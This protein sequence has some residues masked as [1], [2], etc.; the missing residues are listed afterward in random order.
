VLPN[1]PRQH[2]LAEIVFAKALRFVQSLD[3]HVGAE[4]IVSHRRKGVG[5]PS[6][7]GRGP[8]RL[9]EEFAHAPLG[10]GVDNSEG[11]GLRQRHGERRDR[12]FGLA[13]QVKFDHLADVHPVDVVGAENQ[14]QVRFVLLDQIEV[15]QHRIG[16]ALEPPGVAPKHLRRHDG[17]ELAGQ[18]GRQHPG[19]AHVLDKFLR[20][21]LDQ[22]IDR[23]DPGIDQVRQ[24]EVHDAVT[25]AER[26]RRLGTLRGQRIEARALPAGHDESKNPATAHGCPP[27]QISEMM[28]VVICLWS[29][30]WISPVDIF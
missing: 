15:L 9:L 12:H 26:D 25:T 11:A 5:G 1:Q 17:H 19:L 8:C 14:H 30:V 28:L 6:G 20:L 18:H 4:Q 16:R 24:S 22:Q 7:H 2:V 13:L 21:V 23:V 3:Q 27:I 10:V 29:F